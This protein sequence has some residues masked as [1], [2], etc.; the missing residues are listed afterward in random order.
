MVNRHMTVPSHFI[1]DEVKFNELRSHVD[2]I[3]FPDVELPQVP[4]RESFTPCGF[5]DFDWIM[6]DHFWPLLQK[7]ASQSNDHEI[8]FGVLEPDP[9]QYFKAHFG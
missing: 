2:T 4:F 3:I 7:L 6:C 9:V 1:T 5:E 8:I